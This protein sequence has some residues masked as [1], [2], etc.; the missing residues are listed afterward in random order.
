MMS[1]V[2]T[3]EIR[4][5]TGETRWVVDVPAVA[6]ARQ[7]TG[8]RLAM[9]ADDETGAVATVTQLNIVHGYY[10][11]TTVL[12]RLVARGV[13]EW[14]PKSTRVTTEGLYWTDTDLLHRVV[15]RIEGGMWLDT[16][17]DQLPLSLRQALRAWWTA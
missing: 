17:T 1:T 14:R 5:E 7:P 3:V 15:A 11:S 4:D 9:G 12:D 10:G 16:P 8:A 6:I 2:D 13:V